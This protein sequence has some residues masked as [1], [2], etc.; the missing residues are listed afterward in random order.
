MKLLKKVL[1]TIG[2]EYGSG[3]KAIAEAREG[4]FEGHGGP[5]GAVIVKDGKISTSKYM[6]RT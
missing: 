2:R 5:F 6:T 4:I 1:I 3:G